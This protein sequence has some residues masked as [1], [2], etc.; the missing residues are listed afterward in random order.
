[1]TAVTSAGPTPMTVACTSGVHKSRAISTSLAKA[2]RLHH[3]YTRTATPT[4][5]RSARG[6]AAVSGHPPCG[7][8]VSSNGGPWRPLHRTGCRFRSRVGAG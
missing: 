2:G 8:S 3:E 1:M 6:E 5:V 7:K 4:E